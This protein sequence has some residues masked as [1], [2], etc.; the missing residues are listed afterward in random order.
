MTRP[1]FALYRSGAVAEDEASRRGWPRP[2]DVYYGQ[3]FGLYAVGFGDHHAPGLG[4]PYLYFDRHGVI[5]GQSVLVR[6]QR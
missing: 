1:A 2:F 3:E 6:A 4:V 5:T